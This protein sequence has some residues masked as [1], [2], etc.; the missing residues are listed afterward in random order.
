MLWYFNYSHIKFHKN[1]SIK[2]KRKINIMKQ[3][4]LIMI[5]YNIFTLLKYIVLSYFKI[6][7]NYLIK[8]C[9]ML[10]FFFNIS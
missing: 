2:F 10:I 3:I 5:K 4:I 7:C 9:L 1:K 6:F 8:K